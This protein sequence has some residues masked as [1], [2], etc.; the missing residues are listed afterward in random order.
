MVSDVDDEGRQPSTPSEDLAEGE[1]PDGSPPGGPDPG[2]ADSGVADPGVAVAGEPAATGK[3]AVEG[4]ETRAP[5]GDGR[6]SASHDDSGGEKAAAPQ[7]AK[8]GIDDGVKEVA[9]RVG[10]GRRQ[11]LRRYWPF[12]ALGASTVVLGVG[13]FLAIDGTR[14]EPTPPRNDQAAAPGTLETLTDTEA[15]FTLRYP[16]GWQRIPVPPEASDLRVVLSVASIDAGGGNRNPAGDDGMWVRVFPPDKIDQKITEFDAEIKALTG[17]KPCGTPGSA[18][19][20]QEQVTVAGL[21][22]VRYVYTSTDQASGQDSVHIQYFL[23]R[24]PGNLYV[25]VFQAIPGS[26]L[27]PLAPAFDQVLSGFQVNDQVPSPS[28]T[29]TTPR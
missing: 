25:L 3:V 1:P 22:G 16:K 14:D 5:D 8:T 26:D 15:G 29:T 13:L 27:G 4:L 10:A 12:A 7:T 18:C 20:R 23:R 9:R 6:D 28:T 11:A 17:D 2:V 19:L 24:A 21:N